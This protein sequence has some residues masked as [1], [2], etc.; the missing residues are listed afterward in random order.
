[1][2]KGLGAEVISPYELWLALKLEVPPSRI[3]YNGVHKDAASLEMAVKQDIR[4]INIDSFQ[5]I[6][7]LADIARRMGKRPTVGVRVSTG[8]GW[9]SQF[10]LQIQSGEALKAYKLMV[11]FR[12]LSDL[13]CPY[14]SWHLNPQGI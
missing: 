2:R 7:R 8:I 5:E 6:E 1:M 3:I 11:D 14:P 4:L 12:L 10:G 13:R 9:S